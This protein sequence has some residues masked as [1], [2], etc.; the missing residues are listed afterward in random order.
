MTAKLMVLQSSDPDKTRLVR[1]PVDMEEH[2]AYRHATGVIASV[3]EENTDCSWEDVE[4]ALDAH[5]FQAVEFVIGP[6]LVC[7]H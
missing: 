7:S 6:A 2:E 1:I 4:D 5:G 3:Q